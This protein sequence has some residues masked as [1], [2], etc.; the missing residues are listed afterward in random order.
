MAKAAKA[1]KGRLTQ[2]LTSHAQNID[3]TI[4]MLDRTVGGSVMKVE[5]SEVIKLGD[6]VSKQATIAGMLWS[7]DTLNVDE[8]EQNM[9]VYYNVLQGFLLNCVGKAIS[10]YDSGNGKRKLFIPRL[11][12]SVWEACAAIKKTPTSNCMAVGRAITRVAVSVKDVVR[13]MKELKV[14]SSLEHEGT[15]NCA[16]DSP[17]LNEDDCLNMDELGTD[18]SPEEMTVVQST[19]NVISD[20]LLVFKELIRFISDL[21]KQP[22]KTEVVDSLEL[23]LSICQGI[24][25]DVDELGASVYSPQELSLMRTTGAKIS[26]RIEKIRAE[27]AALQGSPEGLYQACD[28]LNCSLSKFE[29]LLGQLHSGLEDKIE[30]L[31][32]SG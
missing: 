8:L 10:S 28:C 6:E 13:E 4:Q 24:G 12:G 15:N 7:G 14:D 23:L 9:G 32:V 17:K 11:S 5:W 25:G 3:E 26:N 20:T 19:I 27:V 2:V 30:G 18:L 16:D 1:A 22:N 29:S 31:T 21:V